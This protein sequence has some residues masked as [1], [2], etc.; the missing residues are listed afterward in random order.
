MNL[1]QTKIGLSWPLLR[2]KVATDDASGSRADP[3]ETRAIHL[4]NR[5]LHCDSHG[6]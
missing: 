1:G 6:E 3:P 5:A 4:K 2:T